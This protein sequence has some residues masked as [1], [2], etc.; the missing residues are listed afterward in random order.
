MRRGFWLMMRSS[1]GEMYSALAGRQVEDLVVLAEGRTILELSGDVSCR[2]TGSNVEFG[3]GISPNGSSI[4]AP[5]C[6]KNFDGEPCTFDLIKRVVTN[7]P[8]TSAADFG[9]YIEFGLDR[10]FNLGMHGGGFNLVSTEN[11][12]SK[13]RL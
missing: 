11:P 8:V 4:A 3:S 1:F 9:D 2:F 6:S 13:H 7:L 5:I 12:I 10:R